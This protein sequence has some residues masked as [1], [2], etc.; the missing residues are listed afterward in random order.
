[1]LFRYLPFAAA[2]FALT[3]LSTSAGALAIRFG[4]ANDVLPTGAWTMPVLS[5]RNSTLP[6]LISFTALPVGRHR[7]GL[8]VRHQAARAEH[9]AEPADGAHHVGRRD[10]GVEVDPA[11]HDLLDELFAADQVGAGLLRFL[12][13][14]GAGDHQH[15]LR[16]AEAVRQDD[17]AAHHL[18]GVL[19]VDPEPNGQRD[20]LVELGELDFSTSGSA[21][22]SEYGR[23][24]TCA[25]AAVNF[26][27]CLRMIPCW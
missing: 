15:A 22:A 20:G 8:R 6:A 26:L 5:T 13:L 23:S 7:A 14:L 12:L 2:G 11:A 24:S 9:L 18:V 4:A 16:L 10:D 1:M 17:G 3:M 21:S 25:L 27:P 19:R